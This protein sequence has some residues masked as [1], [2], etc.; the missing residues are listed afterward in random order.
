MHDYT[1]YLRPQG[2][3]ADD[4]FVLV[5]DGFCWPAF[6]LST[7]WALWHRLW[8]VALL[9]AVAS[10]VVEI[11]ATDLG[12][13]FIGQTGAGLGLA[14]AFGYAASGLWG[15]TLERNGYVAASAVTG[16]NLA[17]AEQE[18][19]NSMGPSGMVAP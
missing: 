4:G 13:G 15:W 9:I 19:L 1:V 3:A 12:L 11:I 14:A 18:Y 7:I 16:V 17:D 5:K 2:A 10:V 8:L 6:F